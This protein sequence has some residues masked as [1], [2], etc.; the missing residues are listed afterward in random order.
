MRLD[1]LNLPRHWSIPGLPRRS[2]DRMAGF[3][4]TAL[5]LLPFGI[6]VVMVVSLAQRTLPLLETAVTNGQTLVQAASAVLFGQVWRP[7]QG[8]FGLWPFVL[9]T[10]W[11]TMIAMLIAVPPCILVALYLAEYAGPRLAATLKPLLDLL[12]G[13]PSVVYGVWGLVAVVPFAGWLG[14]RLEDLS[15]GLP[16]FSTSNPT[17][18]SLLAGGLVLAVMVAPF[19]IA[20]TYEVLKATPEGPFRAALAL[21]ATRW[22]AIRT[23]IW[24]QARP[25]VFAAVVLGT[26]RA[27]GETMAVM[28]VVGNIA[29]TPRS[30]FDAAYPLPALIANN[31]G[32]M[33]SI[34]LYDSALL[35]A[36]LVLLAVVLAFN[37]LAQ[38]ILLQIKRRLKI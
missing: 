33:M 30:I 16:L 26:A 21:G 3:L 13:I 25:G 37:L 7:L 18:F 28:M 36:A 34:P 22:Q 2:R 9:G 17:G 4:L 8:L 38:L 19:V 1:S 14:P 5:A 6:L 24:P 27:L 10:L 31:Y 23:A 29:Q 15:G 11:V 35:G 12:A 32:E 20:M